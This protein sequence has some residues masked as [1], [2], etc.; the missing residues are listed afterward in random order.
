MRSICN[1]LIEAWE[2]RGLQALPMELQGLLVRDLLYA[3]RPAKPGDRRGVTPGEYT[4]W[5]GKDAF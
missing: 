1:P 3:D 4:R 5:D 2:N